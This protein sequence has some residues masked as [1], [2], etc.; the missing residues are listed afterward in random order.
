MIPN[1]ECSEG[2]QG[3]ARTACSQEK[4]IKQTFCGTGLP[5]LSEGAQHV[6]KVCH[7]VPLNRV[8]PKHIHRFWQPCRQCVNGLVFPSP[9]RFSSLPMVFG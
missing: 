7:T 5:D 2:V 4:G 1:G 3:C 6:A 8:V 9:E